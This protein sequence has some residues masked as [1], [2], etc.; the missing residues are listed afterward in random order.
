MILLDTNVL[1]ELMLPEVE[2]AVV[3]WLNRQPRL[4]VWISA[5]T[6]FEVRLGLQSKAGGKQRDY[7]SAAFE[8]VRT[9]LIE[10]RV[11]AFDTEAA[12]EAANLMAA[13]NKRGFNVDLRDTMIAG[14]ALSRRATLATRNT[15][16]FDDLQVPVV[17]PW[18]E[19]AKL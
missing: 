14:I 3:S 15:R 18:H 9:R 6:I 17:N 8:Q 4:S 19:G 1:S 5:V 2:P 12:I 13:R 10:N 7:L 11:L 16:H